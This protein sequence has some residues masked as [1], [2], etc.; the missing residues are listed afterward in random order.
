VCYEKLHLNIT[1]VILFSDVFITVCCFL[2]F[3]LVCTICFFGSNYKI[4]KWNVMTEFDI[5]VY[6][7]FAVTV[8]YSWSKLLIFVFSVHV[9]CSKCVMLSSFRFRK[10]SCISELYYLC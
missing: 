2:A 7:V 9:E 10:H 5:T 3:L 8:Y 1:V 6:S 4:L